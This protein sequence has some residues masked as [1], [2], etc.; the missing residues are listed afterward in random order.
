MNSSTVFL[1]CSIFAL[2]FLFIILSWFLV[3]KLY[4]YDPKI[5]LISFTLI[6][7]FWVCFLV[8]LIISL[9]VDAILGVIL[10]PFGMI[11]YKLKSG[12][13][14]LIFFIIF[15]LSVLIYNI[16]ILVYLLFTDFMI[17][18]W[19]IIGLY[20]TNIVLLFIGLKCINKTQGIYK[21][22]K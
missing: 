16:L 18:S 19:F 17:L 2:C 7:F 14:P 5:I 1:T 13:K 10:I 20:I 12:K 21:N 11:W 22:G 6:L 3:Q 15:F 8:R 9:S 4:K